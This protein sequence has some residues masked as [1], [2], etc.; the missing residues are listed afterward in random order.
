MVESE[1]STSIENHEESEEKDMRVTVY[2]AQHTRIEAELAA[3]CGA[4]S[5]KRVTV[6]TVDRF[7]GSECDIIVVSTT[8]SNLDSRVLLARLLAHDMLCS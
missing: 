1:A 2:F 8:R 4:W 5:Q 7:Q 3:Q 6:H